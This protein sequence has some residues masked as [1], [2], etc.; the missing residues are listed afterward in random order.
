M[1]T[2]F[3]STLVPVLHEN[4]FIDGNS[5]MTGN[6]GTFEE[7]VANCFSLPHIATCPWSTSVCRLNCYVHGL[8]KNAWSIYEGFLNN[9]RILNW[10][11]DCH[12]G[13]SARALGHWIN[14]HC[15]AFRWHVSGDVMSARHANWIVGVCEYSPDVTHRIYTRS[16]RYAPILIQAKNLIVNL[17]A[18]RHNWA[19]AF[20]TW[21]GLH[22][23]TRLTYLST[24]DD[25]PGDLPLGSVIFP[26]YR[27]RQGRDSMTVP[28]PGE[29]PMSEKWF[30]QML[31][32][33]Q[34]KMVCPA[35]YFG[36]SYFMRC[37]ICKKCILPIGQ[38]GLNTKLKPERE[39]DSN[40]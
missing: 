34:R 30:W 35:D 24:G 28:P 19:E 11:L 8:S 33:E 40:E 26:T 4:F 12:P 22:H 31:T 23:W 29:M 25:I 1:E 36:Q 7:P 10:M 38:V 16:F 17:S 6:E 37:G 15:L 13:P 3:T 2:R 9:L 21:R 27:L 14:E 18:D 5:K 39:E 32:Q 20:K